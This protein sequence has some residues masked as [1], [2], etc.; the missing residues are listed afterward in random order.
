MG[1]EVPISLMHSLS[2]SYENQFFAFC[3]SLVHKYAILTGVI[4]H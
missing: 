1:G 3:C 2:I 4:K